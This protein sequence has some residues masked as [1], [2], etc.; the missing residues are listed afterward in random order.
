MFHC[1]TQVQMS[2]YPQCSM[3]RFKLKF[4]LIKVIHKACTANDVDTIDDD[5]PKAEL[6]LALIHKL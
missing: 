5:L 3:F 2:P 6:L 4:F 1:S